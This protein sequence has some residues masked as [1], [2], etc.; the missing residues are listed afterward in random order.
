[1]AKPLDHD[2]P[3]ASGP[4]PKQPLN[5]A[6][7]VLG[8]CL[9][10]LLLLSPLILMVLG[11]GMTDI[12]MKRVLHRTPEASELVCHEVAPAVVAR[13]EAGLTAPSEH[14]RR[15]RAVRS[16]DNPEEWYIAAEVQGIGYETDGD[17]VAWRLTTRG[18]PRTGEGAPEVAIATVEVP[19]GG[20]PR[21]AH[22]DEA[23][24]ETPGIMLYPSN[25]PHL[26]TINSRPDLADAAEA[27]LA[28][29]A[30][31]LVCHPAESAVVARI[32]AALTVPE[33]RVRGVRAVRSASDPQRWIVA[34]DLEGVGRYEGDDDIG[35]WTMRWEGATP[36]GTPEGPAPVAAVNGLATQAG[37]F[38][39]SRSAETRLVAAAVG[40]ANEALGRG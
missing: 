39:R 13:I 17:I 4:S 21:N 35:M 11:M 31:E 10:L 16:A 26:Y 23:F 15:A 7:I 12:R 20:Y 2:H 9:G 38:P 8:G 18:D 37:P 30:P 36:P 28:P 3:G 5:W 27:C 24:A 29:P 1:M 34:A 33:T 19:P 25:F 32:E 14:L 40:C 22:D 6:W